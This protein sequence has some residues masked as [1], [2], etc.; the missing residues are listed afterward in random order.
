MRASP[1]KR[2]A[3]IAALAASA[4]TLGAC[5]SM[6]DAMGIGKM[7]PDEYAVAPRRPLAMPPDYELRA[8]QP[9]AASPAD[10]SASGT[11][12][13]ALSTAGGDGTAAPPPPVEAPPSA[14]P[15][16]AP[17]STEPPMDVPQ[18]SEDQDDQAG[19]TLTTQ[20]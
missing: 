17:P 16:E 6:Q 13:R 15:I 18:A 14:G 4:A 10:I 9:G 8:P 2:I 7:P 11:A 1:V 5:E 3:V 12:A 20:P 19:R